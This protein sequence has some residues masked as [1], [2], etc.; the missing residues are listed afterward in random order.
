MNAHVNTKL[1]TPGLTRAWFV[2]DIARHYRGSGWGASESSDIATRRLGGVEVSGALD[3]Q[4]R[5]I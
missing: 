3:A 4:G 5:I 1:I 2:W